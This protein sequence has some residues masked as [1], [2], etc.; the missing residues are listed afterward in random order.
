VAA[1]G[2]SS[3][4]PSPSSSLRSLPPLIQG[5]RTRLQQGIHQPKK[6]TDGTIRYGLFTAIGEP[7]TLSDA[8][9]DDRWCNSMEEEYNA[10]MENN[11]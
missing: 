2:A 8:M 7:T 11:T 1:S 3:G 4:T 10:L 9:E 5:P 6:Y